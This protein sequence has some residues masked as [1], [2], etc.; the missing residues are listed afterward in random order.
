MPA[1]STDNRRLHAPQ[2]DREV[3][4]VPPPEEVGPLAEGERP[5]RAGSIRCSIP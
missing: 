3:L 4:I 5:G 1:A 2:H